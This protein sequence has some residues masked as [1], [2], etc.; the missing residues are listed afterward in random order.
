MATAIR[1]LIADDHHVV[2]A[3]IATFLVKESDIQVVGELAEVHGLMDA[4][5]ELR[6]HVLLLDAHMPGHKVIDTARALREKHPR[7]RIL[8]LSAYNRK[9][10][11]VG[12]LSAGAV[13]Y[14]LKDESPET[15][16][17]AVRSVARGHKWLSP[18]VAEVLVSAAARDH[19][20]PLEKLTDREAEGV[21]LMASG[22]RNE[23]IAQTLK[24]SEQTVKNHVRSIF[25][26]LGVETRVEAVLYAI[27]HG[28]VESSPQEEPGF[29]P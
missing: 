7:T 15:L 6:P 25:A 22:C 3:A 4:V 27:A 10:Y 9:E 13:G 26:K 20:T 28:W 16:A 1:V 14:V 21:R 8:V 19:D 17:Q 23:R 2:R 29:D 12:L 24:I 11:V 5:A 18:R